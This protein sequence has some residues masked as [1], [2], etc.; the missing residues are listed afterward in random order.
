MAFA[1]FCLAVLGH[2][3]RNSG[4]ILQR[5]CAIPLLNLSNLY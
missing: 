3:R 5:K 1:I 4:L 2:N